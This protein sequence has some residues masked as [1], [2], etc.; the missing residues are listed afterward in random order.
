MAMTERTI[1]IL[2]ASLWVL[3][4]LALST[5]LRSSVTGATKKD[6]K[7]LYG[8]WIGFSAG[9]FVAGMLTA[10]RSTR[11][12]AGIRPYAFWGGIA[13]I[14]IGLGIRWIAIATLKRF[15]TVDV[16]IASD[17]KVIQHGVYRIVRHPSYAGSL[18]CSIGLG[19][20]FVNWLSFVA[21]LLFALAGLAYRISVEEDALTSALGDEYRQY[22][23]RT[24]R[25]IPGVYCLALLL[26]AVPARSAEILVLGTY[27]MANPGHDINNVHADDVLAPKRQ[28]EIAQL[29]EVL[30]KFQPTKVAVEVNPGSKRMANQYADY[31]A[32]KYQLTQNEIDQIGY[33]LAKELG[34][35]TIYGVDADGD[36]PWMPLQ[37]YAKAHDRT[38]EFD[39]ISNQWTER[40]NA[41]N[42]YLPAHTVLEVLLTINS[43]EYAAAEL[44]TY[45]RM[46]RLG[47]PYDFA[48]ADLLADWYRRNIRIY[49]NVLQ[50]IDSPNERILVVFGAG[51]LAWLRQDITNNPDLKLR[52]LSDFVK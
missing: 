23:A 43:D 36:F 26:I 35:K 33:R 17:H 48:G 16:A 38:R 27:H 4:E 28:A 25:L 13:L 47:E 24:K 40:A 30:K 37:D 44:A 31:L 8:M 9:P 10:V 18:L 29:I 42:A 7:S 46:P 49:S 11:M 32:G 21:V 6:K 14:L 12:S 5:R 2:V 15:F 1:L 19:L 50:L 51:H 3:S 41:L 20:A 52:K 45:Y 34:H 39:A 22:A